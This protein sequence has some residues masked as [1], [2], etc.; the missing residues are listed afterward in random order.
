MNSDFPKRILVTGGGTGIGLAIVEACLLRGS[1]VIAIGRRPLPLANAASLGAQT[2]CANVED[3]PET[4]LD[5]AGPIDGLVHNAGLYVHS[6]LGTW[7]KERWRQFFSVHVEAPAL[8]SQSFAE[9]CKGPG[10]IVAVSSTLAQRPA[11][12]ATPYAASKAALVGLIQGLA[13]ELAPRGIRANVVLPGVV[14]TEMTAGGRDGRSADEQARAFAAL[15][16]LG[17]AGTPQE[18]AK[19]VCACLENPWMTGSALTIDGGLLI[20]PTDLT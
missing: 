13:L 14:P 6:P 9:R 2:F 1:E 12:G 18:V 16:P 7:S 20:G 15:H 11:P 17:R 3:D 8:L 19:V 10:A 5:G 4:I